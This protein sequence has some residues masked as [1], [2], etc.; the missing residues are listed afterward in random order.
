[1]ADLSMTKTVSDATPNVGD[2]ITFTVTLSNQGPDAATGV[3]GG[4]SARSQIPS[5]DRASLK[6]DA[7]VRLLTRLRECN[8]PFCDGNHRGRSHAVLALT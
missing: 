5:S 1:M 4:D 8:R 2:Q 7:L 6:R 3:P